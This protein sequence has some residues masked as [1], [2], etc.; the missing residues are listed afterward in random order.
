MGGWQWVVARRQT[1]TCLLLSLLALVAELNAEL[2]FA[3]HVKEGGGEAAERIARK[4]GMKNMGEVIPGSDYFLLRTVENSRRKRSVGELDHL[5]AEDSEID[6]SEFQRPLERVKRS[7]LPSESSEEVGRSRR[8]SSSLEGY[9]YKFGR[10][11]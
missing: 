11:L 6:W 1:S 10:R 2:D 3:V 9:S 5:F 4:H 8:R 7:P